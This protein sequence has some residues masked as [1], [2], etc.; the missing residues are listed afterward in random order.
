MGFSNFNALADQ[1]DYLKN[2]FNRLWDHLEGFC[3]FHYRHEPDHSKRFEELAITLW[4]DNW[5]K[6]IL[7]SDSTPLPF[8]KQI[9]VICREPFVP[10]F[11]A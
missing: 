10:D 8:I 6:K 9:D 7:E 11:Q 1:R 2:L 4:S 5:A 3:N